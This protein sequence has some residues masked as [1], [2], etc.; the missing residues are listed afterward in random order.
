M[1]KKK[2]RN[3]RVNILVEIAGWLGAL[4]IILA[5]ALVSFDI[6]SPN[7]TTYQILNITGAGGLV[8][9]SLYKNVKQA[10]LLNIFWA[11]VAGLALVHIIF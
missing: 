4:A 10:V 11:A 9:I 3:K 6:I 8:V 1:N 2:P 5:Y 7:S